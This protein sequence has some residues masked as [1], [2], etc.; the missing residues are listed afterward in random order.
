MQS[1]TVLLETKTKKTVLYKSLTLCAEAKP[2]LAHTVRGCSKLS[3]LKKDNRNP[4]KAS[5]SKK[6]YSDSK[7]KANEDLCNTPKNYTC[8]KETCSYSQ[9]AVQWNQWR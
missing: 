4:I 9:T 5:T 7:M 2:I 1:H 8:A 6:N 3:G